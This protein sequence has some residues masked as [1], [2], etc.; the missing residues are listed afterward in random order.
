[1]IISNSNVGMESVRN[2]SAIRMD[3]YSA[4]IGRPRSLSDTDTVNDSNSRPAT[5]S[6]RD[7]MDNLMKRFENMRTSRIS[8][9]HYEESAMDRIRTECINF[10]IRLLFGGSIDDDEC[11]NARYTDDKKNTGSSGAGSFGTPVSKGLSMY[12]AHYFYESEEVSYKTTGKAVTADGREIEFDLSFSMSRSFEQ[13]YEK[14]HTL[15]ISKLCDPLVINLDTDIAS[16]SDQKF[17]FDIDSDG[18]KDNIS[19]LNKGSGFLA[20]DKNG[21]GT[22]NDGSE[23]FG[24]ASGDG[25]KDLA[26]YDSDGNGWIDEA[27]E[28]WDKLLIY[29]LNEDGSSS[30]YGLSEKGVGAIYLGN[31]S[32]NYSLN[33]SI[34][35]SVNAVIRKTGMFLFENG[36]AGTVQHLDVAS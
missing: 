10:L 18:V 21:D 34:D 4:A 27:D 25:F 24:T 16:V 30:L 32:T 2:Y 33:N 20:L 3:A 1:M 12:E 35:N 6:F 22:V 8:P 36:R 29:S 28:I 15:D 9:N 14:E 11:S 19:M 7:S 13:Y 26:A 31:V 23:L 5:G 17:L